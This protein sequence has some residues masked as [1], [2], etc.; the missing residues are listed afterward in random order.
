MA[1]ISHDFVLSGLPSPNLQPCCL[2]IC[3]LMN[4]LFWLNKAI[5]NLLQQDVSAQLVHLQA[6]GIH[7]SENS[8][9]PL[10]GRDKKLALLLLGPQTSISSAGDI[11]IPQGGRSSLLLFAAPNTFT[12]G[13]FQA[14]SHSE[15]PQSP[16]DLVVPSPS[17]S[18]PQYNTQFKPPL[19]LFNP[20]LDHLRLT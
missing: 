10:E 11:Q 12:L 18:L 9:R 16:P 13:C 1:L 15:S 4:L 20:S 2:Q 17:L 14:L 5:Y 7:S 8:F 6:S 3:D 19:R